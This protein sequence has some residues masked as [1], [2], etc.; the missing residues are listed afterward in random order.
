MLQAN[1][2]TH[3]QPPAATS[4]THLQPLRLVAHRLGR[5]DFGFDRRDELQIAHQANLQG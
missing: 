3:E 5:P 1:A 2:P 4:P